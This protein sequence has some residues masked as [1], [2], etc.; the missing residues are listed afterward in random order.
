[1]SDS[2]GYRDRKGEPLSDVLAWARLHDDPEYRFVKRTALPDLRR[3]VITVWEGVC[4]DPGHMFWTGIFTDVE[5]GHLGALLD[6]WP[7]D[8]EADALATHARAVVAAGGAG[9]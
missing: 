2:I 3:Q 6:E 8:T 5:P 7:S 1:M 9:T 4:R